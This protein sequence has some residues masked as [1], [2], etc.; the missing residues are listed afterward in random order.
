[1][2]ELTRALL[3]LSS[4]PSDIPEE[5]LHTIERFVILLY[6]RTSTCTD[7]DNACKKL[8]ARKNNVELIP[9]TKAALEE[10]VKRAAYQGGQVWGQ[11]LLPAP[12]LPPATSWGGPKVRR[13]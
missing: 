4:A 1:M 8:F 12:E 5:I 13:G 2:P 9:P 6:G 10:H 7:I 3:K 11:M